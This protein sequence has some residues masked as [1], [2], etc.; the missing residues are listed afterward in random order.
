MKCLLC[1]EPANWSLEI[2][3][4][5]K[6]YLCDRHID[7]LSPAIKDEYYYGREELQ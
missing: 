4:L 7:I 5:F 1:V 2:K 6:Q 3:G